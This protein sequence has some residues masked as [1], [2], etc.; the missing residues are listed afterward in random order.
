[1]SEIIMALLPDP[2]DDYVH[3]LW[4]AGFVAVCTLP[5]LV[6]VATIWAVIGFTKTVKQW[7]AS[8]QSNDCPHVMH[9]RHSK[10]AHDMLEQHLTDFPK[11]GDKPGFTCVHCNSTDV[12]KIRDYYSP[13]GQ[14]AV[15]KCGNCDVTV[16]YH[17]TDDGFV[18]D[19]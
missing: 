19:E 14:W 9:S 6:L 1:M 7:I 2:N 17:E 5:Y 11:E 16:L 12:N 13:F 15:T 8:N 3:W 4:V 18:L 10:D